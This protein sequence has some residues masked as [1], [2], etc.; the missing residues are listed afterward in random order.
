M[1]AGISMVSK[2]YARANIP[3]VDVY[4]PTKPKSHILYL[5][6]NNLYGWAM[7]LALPMGSF[8]WVDDCQ[9]LE[10]TIAQHPAESIEGFIFEVEL[11]YPEELHEA[12]NT[13]PPAP[14]RMGW[15]ATGGYG[16]KPT[17]TLIS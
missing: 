16:W 14:E 2:R 3:R 6:A 11:E 8:G 13:Y 12:R 7:S 10:I 1:R 15:L 9:S 4:G 5:D 17:P